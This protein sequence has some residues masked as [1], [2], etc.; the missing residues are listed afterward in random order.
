MLCKNTY[1]QNNSQTPK[2]WFQILVSVLQLLISLPR[3]DHCK[4]SRKK[5]CIN[6]RFGT[7]RNDQM[8]T[9]MFHFFLV[10]RFHCVIVG[11]RDYMWIYLSAFVFEKCAVSM[12]K[13]GWEKKRKWEKVRVSSFNYSTRIKAEGRNCQKS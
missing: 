2:S 6:E 11:V 1:W 10:T 12:R 8:A 3:E 13:R 9:R 5:Q 7:L 4:L